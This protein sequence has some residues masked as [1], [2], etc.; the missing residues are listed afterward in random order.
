MVIRGIF[1]LFS[2]S[3]CINGGDDIE[4]D[5]NILDRF[6]SGNI[7]RDADYEIVER[8]ASA[9]LIRMGTTEVLQKNNMIKLQPTA[10]CTKLGKEILQIK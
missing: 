10:V 3:Y 5:L 9:G 7:I 1:N 8:L 6:K 4:D 2:S